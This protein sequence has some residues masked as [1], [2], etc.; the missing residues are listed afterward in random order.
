M[1]FGKSQHANIKNEDDLK[2]E[3][4][5]KYVENLKMKTTSKMKM[6]PKIDICNI[7]GSIVYYLKKMRDAK[8]GRSRAGEQ[9]DCW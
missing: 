2:N 1:K 7:V 3:Y 6:I 4:N 8:T 5:L 9:Q